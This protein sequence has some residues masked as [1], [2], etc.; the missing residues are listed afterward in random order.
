MSIFILIAI[1]RSF[2]GTSSKFQNAQKMI[3]IKK[4]GTGDWNSGNAEIK[5]LSSFTLTIVSNFSP[6][7]FTARLG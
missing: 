2:G 5:R 1:S 7:Q 6:S 4:G 3:K